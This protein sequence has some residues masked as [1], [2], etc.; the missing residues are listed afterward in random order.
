M[1]I[2]TLALASVLCACGPTAP[3]GVPEYSYQIVNTFPHDPGAFA[4]GLFY[5][6]G[7]LYEST[8]L[9]YQSSIRKV[10]VETGE[11]VQKHDL[12]GQYFGEGIVNWKDRLI[13]LTYRSQLGFVYGLTSF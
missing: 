6:N 8:G 9:E 13:G 10:R 11:V 3:A 4:E 2:L 1:R 12:P 5:L 7:F